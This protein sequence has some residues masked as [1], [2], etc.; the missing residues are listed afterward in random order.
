M[1]LEE[2]R[3]MS[4]DVPPFTAQCLKKLSILLTACLPYPGIH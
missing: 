4:S 2:V 3:E 1:V